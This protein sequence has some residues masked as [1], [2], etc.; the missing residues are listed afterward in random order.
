[1]DEV[2]DFDIQLKVG[3]KGEADFKRY[4]SSLVPTKSVD[5][6]QDF[7]LATGQTVELKTDTY[8]MERTPNFFMELFGDMAKSKIG[9]PWRALQDGVEFFVYYFTKNRTFFWFRTTT[10][11]ARL[12]SIVASN[13]LTPK[14]I[15]NKQWA[16]IGYVVPR[17]M[18]TDII[19]QQDTF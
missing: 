8:D 7:I 14:E 12:D 18:L 5:R 17:D 4:Y 16:G 9:G 13:Q 19:Y 1:M 15:R 3:V 10:L 2:F 6:K 11:C